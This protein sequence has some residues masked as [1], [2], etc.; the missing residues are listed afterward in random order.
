MKAKEE[1]IQLIDEFEDVVGYNGDLSRIE[2][3]KCALICIKYV[4]KAYP[5]T[6]ETFYN[7][8]GLNVI[9][10]DNRKY[11]KEIKQEINKL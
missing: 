7:Y 10:I 11:Y 8:K 6:V 2:A 1:A 4:I 3:K 5:T 9:H